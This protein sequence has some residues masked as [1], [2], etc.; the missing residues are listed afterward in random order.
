MCVLISQIRKLRLRERF[1]SSCAAGGCRRAHPSTP[2]LSALPGFEESRCEK[3]DDSRPLCARSGV[4]QA[5][6][7]LEELNLRDR[8]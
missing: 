7:D 3:G 6:G 5:T 1:V 4:H 8:V 2:V